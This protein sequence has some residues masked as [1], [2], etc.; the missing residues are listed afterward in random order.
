MKIEVSKEWCE[1]MALLEGDSEIG[2][3]LLARDPKPTPYDPKCLELAVY[4]CG[5]DYTDDERDALAQDIQAAI[6]DWLQDRHA[7]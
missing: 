4:F 3:G 6:E 2:A 5:D 7:K 1:R